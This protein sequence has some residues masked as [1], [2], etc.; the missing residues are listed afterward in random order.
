[1]KGS[2]VD[3]RRRLDV[4]VCTERLSLPFS[5]VSSAQHQT[6]RKIRRSASGKSETKA[7]RKTAETETAASAEAK[8][9][10]MPVEESKIRRCKA[11]RPGVA[12]GKMRLWLLV[13]EEAEQ[14]RVGRNVES[15]PFDWP[16]MFTTTATPKTQLAVYGSMRC[17]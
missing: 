10:A 8:V 5:R 1:M 3:G 17:P 2:Q 16:M 7:E 4:A 6:R 9:E 14:G 13:G 15:R 11:E 12:A